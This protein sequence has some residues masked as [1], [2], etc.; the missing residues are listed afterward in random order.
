MC[1]S[2]MRAYEIEAS[3]QSLS[4][5]SIPILSSVHVARDFFIDLL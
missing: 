5:A 2:S 4:V 3:L 1:E